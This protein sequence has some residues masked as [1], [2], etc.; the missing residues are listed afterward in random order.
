[1]RFYISKCHDRLN[2]SPYRPEKHGEY[3]C[4][5]PYYK[6]TVRGKSTKFI[7]DSGAFQDVGNETRLTFEKALKRQ[8]EFEK[9]VTKDSR[10]AEA[11]V[12]YDR[13]VDEQM[14]ES[15]Q[16]KARVSAE[17]SITYVKET[18]D[19][20]KFLVSKRE[21][22]KPRRL[23]LSC[24]GTTVDQYLDCLREIL[25][26][27]SPEDIIG[28]GGFCIISKNREYEKQFYEV[29]Y[30]GFPM[31]REKGII[32]VH[33]FG[34]GMFR[35]LIQ[36][37][38]CAQLNGIVCSYDTSSCEINSVYGK[39]FDPLNAMLV[40]VYQKEQKKNGYVPAELAEFNVKSILQFWKHFS[41]LPLP[42]SFIP[43]LVER[44]KNDKPKKVKKI[45][46]EMIVDEPKD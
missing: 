32:R 6:V 22:L 16:F 29:V 8:L 34:V 35:S 3:L 20:A 45:K 7:I 13:L 38:I 12:S 42:E 27:A 28:F 18:I 15:G 43:G 19:A 17:E 30:R 36:A 46:G 26:I 44:P 2:G 4:I 23:I 24:Q 21:E 33:I 41:Q 1:M 31:I 40:S 11:I 9:T 5:N 14:G 39:V 25:D 37:E 10:P